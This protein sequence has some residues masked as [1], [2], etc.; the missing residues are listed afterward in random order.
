MV[1]DR[2]GSEAHELPNHWIS[3]SVTYIVTVQQVTSIIILF[4]GKYKFDPHAEI[5]RITTNLPK[6]AT[7]E[8]MISANMEIQ[9]VH[10]EAEY[11]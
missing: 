8:E 11:R 9:A 4:L 1:S 7:R 10:A 6:D 3:L 5:D 2:Q